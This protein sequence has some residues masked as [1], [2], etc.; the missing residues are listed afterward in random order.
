MRLVD[1]VHVIQAPRLLVHGAHTAQRGGCN[2]GAVI[3][4]LATDNVFLFRLA[5]QIVIAMYQAQVGVVGFRPGI[6]EKHMV[7][8]RRCYIDQCLGQFH[9]G[10]VGTLEK[11]VV[12]GQFLQLCVDRVD[13]AFLAVAQVA[14]PQSRHAIEH[15]VTVAV[16]DIDMF[17]AG[18]NPAAVLAVIL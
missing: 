13:D 4:I 11:I 16:I 8:L 5:L 18:H 9:R 17:R 14:A 15:P 2:G 10:L 12:V 3:G 1:V 6:G 7:E